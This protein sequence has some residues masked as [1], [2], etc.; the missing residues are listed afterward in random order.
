MGGGDGHNLRY[1]SRVH[2]ICRGEVP[3]S[4]LHGKPLP[5]PFFSLS[6]SVL[7][8]E[9][10]GS[11]VS[12]PKSIPKR[13]QFEDFFAISF[14]NHKIVLPVVFFGSE[15]RVK[16][17]WDLLS[18]LNTYNYTLYSISG[19]YSAPDQAIPYWEKRDIFYF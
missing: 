16:N 19:S 3:V 17:V 8:D 5:P 13:Q 7:T 10:F 18:V 6:C 15:M 1:Q 9:Q 14:E 12:G 11:K 2:H 4:H